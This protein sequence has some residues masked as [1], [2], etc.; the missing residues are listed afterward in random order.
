[1]NRNSI[2]TLS[3]ALLA[4]VV[5][6]SAAL[7]GCASVSDGSFPYAGNDTMP[8]DRVGSA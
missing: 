7:S 1:M 2:S 5:I 8:I 4:V 6:A 3:R